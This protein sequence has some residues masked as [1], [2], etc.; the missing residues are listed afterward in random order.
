MPEGPEIR[1]AA[2]KIQKAIAGKPLAK[3][4]FGFP[5]LKPYE[6]LFTGGRVLGIR[7][8]G[9]AM[10]TDIEAQ[11]GSRYVMYSHNQL[12]GRWSVRKA[13]P[14]PKSTR[15]LR[16]AFVTATHM[17]LLYSATEIAVMPAGEETGHP[18]VRRAGPDV[19]DATLTPEAVAERLTE[20]RFAGRRVGGLLLD[21]G[22]VSGVGNYLRSEAMHLAGVSP[23]A[24][25]K[26]LN[27]E[28]RL[29]LAQA[30]LWT[31]R[32]S[33]ETGGLTVPT[34]LAASL[35]AAGTP[36]RGYRHQVFNRAGWPCRV[37]GGQ[38]EKRLDSGRRVY[39]C[40]GCQP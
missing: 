6:A 19:L 10:L 1:Q 25:V 7:T 26:D 14:Y 28:Q 34:E 13:G 11:D 20:R 12:Y 36:R 5:H 18:F 22:F 15:Q 38:I 16:V 29:K 31:A 24:R 2:D 9:K 40:P 32:Q 17:A 37:C 3:V 23:V 30:I 35:K 4:E 39:I 27:A 33:Y 21:Q 8:L